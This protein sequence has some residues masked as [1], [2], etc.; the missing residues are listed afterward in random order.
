MDELYNQDRTAALID[1][2]RNL[3]AALKVEASDIKSILDKA[4]DE[5]DDEEKADANKTTHLA[6][7]FRLWFWR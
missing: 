1:E 7:R 6:P 2:A 3:T 4:F 5:E